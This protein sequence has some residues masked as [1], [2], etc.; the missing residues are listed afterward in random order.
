MVTLIQKSLVLTYAAETIREHPL[1]SSSWMGSHS[2]LYPEAAPG[3]PHGG[4]G[5]WPQQFRTWPCPP[6]PQRT[7]ARGPPFKLPPTPGA[8]AAQ[9]G[10]RPLRLPWPRSQGNQRSPVCACGCFSP[11]HGG[12]PSTG[13]SGRS[14]LV[15]APGRT[16]WLSSPGQKSCLF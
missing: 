8:F 14:C 6:C 3:L 1:I 9:K 7:I 15:P 10:L 13:P 5:L 16:P 2:H 4:P 12:A 11:P